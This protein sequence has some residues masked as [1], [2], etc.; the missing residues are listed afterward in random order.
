MAESTDAATNGKGAV[1]AAPVPSVVPEK[2]PVPEA[3]EE[4]TPAEGILLSNL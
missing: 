3:V 4:I 1:S 2:T